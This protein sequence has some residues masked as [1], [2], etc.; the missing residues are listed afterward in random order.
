[1]VLEILEPKNCVSFDGTKTRAKIA[2]IF[3]TLI[4]SEGKTISD[5]DLKLCTLPINI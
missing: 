5:I 2:S 4:I 1:M 3:L